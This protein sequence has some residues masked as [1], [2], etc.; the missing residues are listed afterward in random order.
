MEEIPLYPDPLRA[1]QVE[2]FYWRSW[3]AA[4]M[5]AWRARHFPTLL[6]PRFLPY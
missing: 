3:M 6:D 1:M 2:K 4:R 5:A